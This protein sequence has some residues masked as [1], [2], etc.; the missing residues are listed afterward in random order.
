MKNEEFKLKL[1]QDKKPVFKSKGTEKK[2]K[3]ELDFFL[4]YKYE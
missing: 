3:E 2:V 4:K 1:F